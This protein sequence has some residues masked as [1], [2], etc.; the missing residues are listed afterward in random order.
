MFTTSKLTVVWSR[1]LVKVHRAL[2]ANFTHQLDC[3]VQKDGS[4]VWRRGVRVGVVG[5]ADTVWESL[6]VWYVAAFVTP[7]A[8]LSV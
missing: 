5:V 3:V 1:D 2:V 8:V 4:Q 6:C 7:S